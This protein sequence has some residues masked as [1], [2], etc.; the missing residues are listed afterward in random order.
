[1]ETQP[2]NAEQE[3]S[4]QEGELELKD[5]VSVEFKF[6]ETNGQVDTIV[7]DDGNPRTEKIVKEDI[8]LS[9]NELGLDGL[10]DF[11][12]SR[13][14]Y[15]DGYPSR[16]DGPEDVPGSLV[17]STTGMNEALSDKRIVIRKR[18]NS[19]YLEIRDLAEHLRK[20]ADEHEF[21]DKYNE[22]QEEEE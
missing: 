10:K 12:L 5:G 6:R 3:P 15:F 21:D 11:F 18:E 9:F 1:M 22:D 4:F 19:K 13:G 7:D 2:G 8:Y 14:I 17:I 16:T 20:F